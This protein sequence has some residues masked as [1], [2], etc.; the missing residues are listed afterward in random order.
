MK[1]L[2]GSNHGVRVRHAKRKRRVLLRLT[3]FALIGIALLSV[4]GG[5]LAR[6]VAGVKEE[7]TQG[8]DLL[9][10]LRLQLSNGQLAEA[11]QSLDQMEHHVSGAR[12][13]ATGPL[14]QA[15]S[16]LPLVGP[17]FDAVSEISVSAD[18]VLSRAVG[19]LLSTYDSLDWKALSPV[20]GR[21]DA[22]TLAAAE[23]TITSA[24]ATVR[25]SQE[26]LNAIDLSRLVPAVAEPLSTM[27]QELGTVSDALHVAS[28][29]AQLLPP[30]LGQG[31]QRSYLL[32]I[33]NSAESRATGGIPGALA[34]VTTNDGLISLGTQS[35]ASAMGEFSPTLD[36][37]PGQESL[38]TTRLG[39]RMQNVNLTPDFPTAAN[40]AKRMWETRYDG[41]NIDG[42]IALDPVVLAHLL[43]A[44]GPVVLEDPDILTLMDNTDLP[45]SLT[46]AN[47]AATLLSDVY[48]EIDD[49]KTQD[50]YFAAVASSIFDAFTNGI[51]EGGSLVEALAISVDEN[52]LYLW[53]N[54]EAE[55][56]I[57]RST[58][59]GGA[60][61]GPGSGGAAFGVFFNDGTGA[62]MD[63]YA[64]RTVELQR[65][66]EDPDHSRYT[67]RLVVSNTAPT[68]AAASLP[69]YVSGNGMFGVHPGHIR[70][71]YV[72]YGPSQS[73]AEAAMLNGR[74]VPMSSGLHAQ[75]PVGTLTVELAPGETATLEMHFAKV[76][77]T[78]E[79]QLR[80]TPGVTPRNEVVLP[81]NTHPSCP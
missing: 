77:Q 60:V 27:K 4:A 64:R 58:R 52:R 18:D 50:L 48:R 47:I 81:F 3:V 75:R 78:S 28:S 22:S 14:W 19:P 1:A 44:T 54:D 9:P 74:P 30:M 41:E 69:G 29:A 12:S 72:F 15:A 39:S 7:L 31:E 76:V 68:D 16:F 73:I 63:Y 25:L 71:N 35:S 32:L 67:V 40:T 17:S 65:I 38:Y 36:V 45:K 66:C 24:A 70:T 20:D 13:S 26:R 56:E 11:Q 5:L 37:D 51:T 49:P 6:Q 79:P 61:D 62:K 46:S 43:E 23:P 8:M 21:I 57:I 80:V 59:I 34:I 33:Q 53:S 55:Q 42:V 10:K 2:Q